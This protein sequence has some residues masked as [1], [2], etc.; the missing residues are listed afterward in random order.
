[1]ASPSAT[2]IDAPTGPSPKRASWRLWL[3]TTLTS[4]LVIITLAG[5]AV[6]GYRTD[7]KMPSFA[8]LMGHN[9]V[10]DDD[11][12]KTH[13]V[14]ES[15]C[16]E[17]NQT[18]AP[19]EHNY[20]WCKEHGVAQCSLHHPD[21]AQLKASPVVTQIDF[22]R[23]E[24]ALALKPR[25]DNNGRC[26]LHERRIQFASLQSVDKAGVDIAVAE[27]R[28]IT[29]AIVTNGEVLYD[30]TRMAHLASRVSGNVSHVEKQVGDRVRKGDVLALIDAAEV[31]KAK[32]ELLQSIAQVRLKQTNLDRLRPLA[33]DGTLPVRQFREAEAALQEAKIRLL[34]AQQTLSNLGLVVRIEDF[35]NVEIERIAERIQFLGLPATLIES[36][37]GEST[38]SNLF[39]LRTPLDGVVVERKVVAGEVVDATATIFTIADVD[40]M[41]LALSVRQEEAKYIS[42]GQ[43]VLFRPGDGKDEPEIKGAVDWI[44]TAADEQ[45]RT[46]KIRASL[47]NVTYGLRANVFGTGRIVLREEPKAVVVP[48]EAVHWDGCCNVVFVR[49]KNFLQEG[50]PKYFHIRKV[51]LGCKD[52][53]NTEIIVGLLP[54]EVIA[55]KNSVVLEAQ[56]L[57][58][59]LGAGCACCGKN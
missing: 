20:G 35:V 50:A 49:D 41:F 15:V 29:E 36:L 23:A 5:V 14:P 58:S 57:K 7:W 4:S 46:V 47:P 27:V 56:L 16:I 40:R 38:T 11:W 6:V 13:G 28:P 59:N 10:A 52:E 21:V 25:A 2:A 48:N 32:S 39:P 9:A 8:A 34:S 12:C 43:T 19:K 55:C 53:N 22:A 26:K 30:Q 24:R 45:T 31:G 3:R 33:N 51:R 1:M 44:S 18:L 17:C 37:S 54:G 42:L